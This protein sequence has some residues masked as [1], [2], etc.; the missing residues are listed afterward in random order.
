VAP[1][2]AALDAAAEARPVFFRDD[3]AG[4]DDAGLGALLDLFESR[5]LPVD[6][7]VI[8][9]A[10]SPA[11]A[12]DLAARAGNGRLR[13]HQHGYAH[14][15]HQLDGRKCEFG[16]Q[17]SAVA[18]AGDVA[19]GRRRLLDQL[20]PLVDAVFTPPWNRCVDA[21]AAALV[22]EGVEVL[23]RDA[24]APAF[25]RPDLAEVPVTVDWFGRAK[26]VRW[27]RP[28]LA[29]RLAD[30]ISAP[31]PVGIMFHHAVTDA[32]E[33]QA[34]DEVLGLLAAHPAVRAA[35]IAELAAG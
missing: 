12:K 8:P 25:N 24:T 27:T 2:A 28:E 11:L 23:S 17:R 9:I 22:A 16:D 15:N 26:G 7:A 33:R 31:G 35:T 30:A 14:L 20:G 18:Q 29:G 4:W 32:D 10:L 13:V 21:T 5:N 3:D 6:V 19:H 1:V 34:V